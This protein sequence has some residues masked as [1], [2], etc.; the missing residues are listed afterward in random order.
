MVLYNY[1]DEGGKH[2]YN[3]ED[4]VY[5]DKD[6]WILSTSDY[7]ELYKIKCT[8]SKRIG[9]V[10]KQLGLKRAI[11]NIDILHRKT[12]FKCINS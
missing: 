5:K 1:R 3:T 10:S 4:V 6:F 9:I 7:Y 2:M 8:H 11:Q 12:M